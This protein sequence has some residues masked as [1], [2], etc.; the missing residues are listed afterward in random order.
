MTR[1][2]SSPGHARN[3]VFHAVLSCTPHLSAT[4]AAMLYQRPAARAFSYHRCCFKSQATRCALPNRH[5]IHV[6][7]NRVIACVKEA[8]YRLAQAVP[9]CQDQ[10]RCGLL[11]LLLDVLLRLVRHTLCLRGK[12]TACFTG[13]KLLRICNTE[14]CVCTPAAC[15]C[16]QPAEPNHITW[17]ATTFWQSDI[18]FDC[19]TV[20]LC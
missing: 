10:E 17:H 2:A 15:Q 12:L 19:V 20:S 5:N 4:M 6:D 1:L 8:G 3:R 13:P 14:H 7:F 9:V 11:N 18:Y 16:S